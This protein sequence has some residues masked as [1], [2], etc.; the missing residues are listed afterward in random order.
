M[1]YVFVPFSNMLLFFLNYE[2][3][4]R[5]GSIL[6]GILDEQPTDLPILQILEDEQTGEL[7][8]RCNFL[9]LFGVIYFFQFRTVGGVD[10][11]NV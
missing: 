11:H 9:I 8:Q 1:H 2:S 6:F 3:V 5:Q 4:F 10:A 7:R